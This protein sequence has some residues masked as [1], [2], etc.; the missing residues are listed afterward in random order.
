MK[1]AFLLLVFSIFLL[2]KNYSQITFIID[3]L[4]DYTPPEEMLFIAGDFNGWNPGSPAYVM[5]KNQEGNWNI[6]LGAETEG[7]VIQF[8]FTRGDWGKVEK[9]VNGEEIG[10]RV[11][12][13]G[14]DSTVHCIIYNW[15]DFGGSGES[16]AAENVSIMDENFEMP[17][18][19]RT[20]RIWIYLPPDY[21]ESSKNYPVLYMHDGQNLFDMQTSYAGEWEVDETLNNLATQ[22]YEVP[23]V[24]GIDNGGVERIAEYT[25]WVNPSYNSGQG[26]EYIDFIVETLKPYIDANYRT[27]P[28]QNNTGIMGSSL[29]GLISHYGSVKNQD[30][31]GKAGIFSPSYWFSDSIWAFTNE[32]GKQNP[33]RFYQI[34]GQL[35]GNQ[36]VANM[37]KMDTALKAVG[38]TNDEIISKVIAGGEHNEK[39]WR[40]QFEEAY[41]WLFASYAYGISENNQIEP[42]QLYPNPAKHKII[43]IDPDSTETEYISITDSSGKEIK[44]LDVHSGTTLDIVP[45]SNGVYFLKVKKS[46]SVYIGRFVKY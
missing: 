19:N 33:M 10:N 13:F 20:R 25:P 28:D 6:T 23:I 1:N 5:E 27:L 8:K 45:L 40:E 2:T 18:L 4:P 44:N 37:L 14:N 15:A 22:G 9:G 7:T 11:F 32:A 46:K 41:L 30:I 16:T 21:D 42:L 31:F 17:Q 12:T 39:L 26:K 3:S 34:M 29:G 38:F 35:E 24:I 36:A 43:F